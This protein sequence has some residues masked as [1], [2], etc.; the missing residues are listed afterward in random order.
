MIPVYPNY[1]YVGELVRWVYCDTAVVMADLGF[2]V[3]IEVVVRL[4]ASG[5]QRIDTPERGKPG[6]REA[7]ARAR[8]LAPHGTY[9][10][11]T[12]HGPDRDDK[13]GRWV[14]EIWNGLV[15]VGHVLRV[16][17]FDKSHERWNTK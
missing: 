17:G 7:T 11:F 14:G 8:E 16:E 6:Y 13:Y 2:R 15:N 12:C 4:A 9:V 1:S 5:T 10:I 3:A